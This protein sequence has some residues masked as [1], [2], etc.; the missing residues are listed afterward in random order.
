MTLQMIEVPSLYTRAAVSSIDESARTVDLIFSTG[1]AV[2]RADAYGRYREVLSMDPSHVRLDRLNNGAPLLNS[3]SAYS[4]SDVIGTVQPGSA[5]IAGGQGL[6]TVRFSRRD[7]VE[8]I[9]QDVIDGIIR[10][11][12][13]GYRVHKFQEDAAKA[14]GVATRTAVD[15]EPYELSMVSMPADPGAK[16]R[17]GGETNACEIVTRS[18]AAAV[19]DS[20]DADFVRLVR[21]AFAMAEM[22]PPP[23]AF[24]K[25]TSIANLFP[26]SWTE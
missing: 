4:I 7:D 3:H 24:L 26:R 16:V 2:D 17:A 12:S 11:V 13:V 19:D 25:R 1:A 21:Y 18:I 20:A 15:W 23:A 22:E 9:W 10:S 6:A 14:G 5:R 8:A